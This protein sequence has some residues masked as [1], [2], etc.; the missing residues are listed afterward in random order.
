MVQ[1]TKPG[2]AQWQRD[3]HVEPEI[4]VLCGNIPTFLDAELIVTTADNSS[5][6]EV[7][8]QGDIDCIASPR[9]MNSA[10]QHGFIIRLNNDRVS[11]PDFPS[12]LRME[13]LVD[14]KHHTI[15]IYFW[16]I[17]VNRFVNAC[18]S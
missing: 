4:I 15:P 3:F 12:E 17:A 8:D 18:A 14:G 2:V 6:V 5:N 16:R 11:T 1:D 13:I 10:N 9:E 7:L